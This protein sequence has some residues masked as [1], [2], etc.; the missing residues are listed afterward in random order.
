MRR[1]ALA[2]AIVSMLSLSACSSNDYYYN[3]N[4]G[5]G[6]PGSFCTGDRNTICLLAIM[7]AVAGAIAVVSNSN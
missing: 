6:Q 7:G 4:S 2:L 1:T 5:T 3:A